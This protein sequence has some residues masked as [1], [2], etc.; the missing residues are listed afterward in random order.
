MK[1]RGQ[2][3]TGADRVHPIGGGGPNWPPIESEL[4]R[5]GV[6]LR[7]SGRELIGPCPAC[8]GTDRFGVN[9]RKQLWFCRK[10][11]KGGDVADLVQHLDRVD[12][13]TAY[14]MLIGERPRSTRVRTTPKQ[15][16]NRNGD[17]D[18]ERRQHEKAAWRWT[19]R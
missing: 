8:G 15:T 1:E 14:E 19:Q 10:C 17:D 18:Y 5:R 3:H 12:Y 7:R 2:Y 16:H 13:K 6:K 11:G 9:I 4:D